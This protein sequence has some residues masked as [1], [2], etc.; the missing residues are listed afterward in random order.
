MR[1][2]LLRQVSRSGMPAYQQVADWLRHDIAE[3]VYPRDTQ[4]PTVP[5]LAEMYD[6]GRQTVRRAIDQL[7]QA[8]IVS[9]RR[10]G[11][12][13]V[14]GVLPDMG[15]AIMAAFEVTSR[16]SLSLV[17]RVQDRQVVIARRDVADLLQCPPGQQWLKVTGYREG[18]KP[19]HPAGYTEVFVH[20]DYPKV[21]E[22]IN[23]NTRLVYP[24]FRDLYGEQ[25]I[26]F[27]QEVRAVRIVDAAA[28][29]LDVAEG[30]PGLRY[31][32][33]FISAKGMQLEVAVN[34]HPLKEVELSKRGLYP[35][36][37][38]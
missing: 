15:D 9:V 26:E 5:E 17:L 23:R 32:T 10:R 13:R 33:R 38:R 36:P 6:V 34:I 1:V 7:K 31:L 29:I 25:L 22:R 11:G 24:L 16:Y 12:T 27:R 30:S 37:V 19:P 28:R 35:R 20:A 18:G 2:P 21:I 3:G 8:G 14:E 4:L